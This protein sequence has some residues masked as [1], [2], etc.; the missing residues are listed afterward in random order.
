M[1]MMSSV[2]IWEAFVLKYMRKIHK[3]DVL[4]SNFMCIILNLAPLTEYLNIPLNSNLL[5]VLQSYN[6][7]LYTLS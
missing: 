4:F 5:M 3:N 1:T 2:D 6:K 7:R